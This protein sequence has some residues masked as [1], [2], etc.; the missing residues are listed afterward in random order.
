MLLGLFLNALL[1]YYH[2]IHD[3]TW[4][5][6][7]VSFGTAE[8]LQCETRG[9][10]KTIYCQWATSIRVYRV[11]HCKSQ[12][13]KNL[14]ICAKFRRGTAHEQSWTKW[15][16]WYWGLSLVG[17]HTMKWVTIEVVGSSFVGNLIIKWGNKDM[18]CIYH[19]ISCVMST[20]QGT[21]MPQQVL[22]AAKQSTVANSFTFFPHM[23]LLLH[24][25]ARDRNFFPNRSNQ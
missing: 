1:Y 23:F 24:H 16:H 10:T 20:S 13:K 15:E 4:Q 8:F 21:K 5:F 22:E 3:D 6:K 11:F 17:R 12:K 25:L 19:W 7:K 2:W 14:C 9:S 18:W